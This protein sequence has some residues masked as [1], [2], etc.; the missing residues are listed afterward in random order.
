MHELSIANSLVEVATEHATRIS[1]ERVTAITLRVGVL[2]CVQRDAL[3]TCFEMVSRNSIA[4]GA[5]I[6]IVELPVVVFCPCCKKEVELPGV[7]A[8]LCPR[9][10]TPSG[11]VRQGRELEIESI[12]VIERSA[13]EKPGG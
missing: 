8:F 4:E 2:S 1:V 9:C 13:S 5:E 7:Q 3:E 11:D 6:H 10:N 12:A